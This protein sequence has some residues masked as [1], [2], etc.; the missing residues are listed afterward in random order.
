LSTDNVIATA[1]A[2]EGARRLSERGFEAVLLPE[3]A[4]TAAP[5]AAAF[6]GTFSVRPELVTELIL[7]VGQS[8]KQQ[9]FAC[10][11]L[12]SAH[13]DPAHVGSLRKA[14]ERLWLETELPVA[15][16]DVTRR[17]LASQLTEEF[18]SGAC[19]AG[20]YE[21]SIVLAARPELVRDEIQGT[22]TPN[23]SSLSMAIREGKST[24]QEAG[25]PE[26]Y[27]GD[28]AA[29]SPQEGRETIEL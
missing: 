12:A 7:D 10:L 20:R 13:L 17:A 6:P 5:F 28:P 4:Y 14:V 19:H 1:M 22:L 8:L 24:F 23:P 25:G 29:A 26:A 11:A 21:G 27:F 16:P 2:E 9:G 15:F 18:Q 3:I